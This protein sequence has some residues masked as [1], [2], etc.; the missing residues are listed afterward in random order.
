M[1][2]SATRKSSAIPWIIFVVVEVPPF[3]L[4]FVAF[5]PRR[6]AAAAPRL[7]LRFLVRALA[8][9]RRFLAARLR[10]AARVLRET[11]RLPRHAS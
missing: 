4:C 2:G 10:L 3:F 7:A 1:N 9:A 6:D 8:L 11:L 5:L